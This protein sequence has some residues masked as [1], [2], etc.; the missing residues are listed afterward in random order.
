MLP[1][2]LCPLLVCDCSHF[3]GQTGWERT[4]EKE[5][6]AVST[7]WLIIVF[8]VSWTESRIFLRVVCLLVPFSAM[9]CLCE[10]PFGSKSGNN[11]EKI[12]RTL[13]LAMSFYVFH[14]LSSLPAIFNL[15]VSS[16]NWFLYFVQSFSDN[17]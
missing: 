12:T 11:K 7:L 2:S 15:S 3:Q 13:T 5:G 1:S 6:D 17:Q 14:L 16:G 8:L 10:C 9:H 4:R